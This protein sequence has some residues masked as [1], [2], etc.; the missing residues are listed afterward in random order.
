MECGVGNDR[1]D[2]LRRSG[3]VHVTAG[4]LEMPM[5]SLWK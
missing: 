1:G 4:A 3:S 5:P 2:A